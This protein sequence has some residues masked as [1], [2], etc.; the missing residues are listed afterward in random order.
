[1][2]TQEM[3][4]ELENI[5]KRACKIIFGWNSKYSDLV[6]QGRIVRL[7]ERRHSL[8]LN[9]AKKSE[10]NPRFTNWFPKKSYEDLNL[11]RTK[12]FEEVYA[13]TERLKNSPL[14]YMRRAL[15]AN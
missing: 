11:R 1:M 5:H 10:A 3:S 13:R 4:N 12:T 8:I 6:E 7:S 2:L 9:F 14:F 15:N